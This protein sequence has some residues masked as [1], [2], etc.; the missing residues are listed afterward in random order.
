MKE[1]HLMKRTLCSI[2]ALAVFAF[3]PQA[4]AQESPEPDQ[5]I[6]LDRVVVTVDR[7]E[8]RQF[9]VKRSVDIQD[10]E[11]IARQQPKSIPDLLQ[12][13]PA[14]TVQKTNAGAGAPIIR[15]LIGP[16]NLILFDGIRVSNSTYRTG[17]NQYLALM[18]PW[19]LSSFELLRGPGSVLYGSDAMGG[20]LHGLSKNPRKL[21]DRSWGL[22]GRLSFAS[23]YPGLGGSLQADLRQGDYGGYVGASFDHFGE[24][25]AG[26]G[27]KQPLSDYQRSAIRHKSTVTLAPDLMLTAAL[28]ETSIRGAGRAEKINLGRHRNYDNDDLLSYVRLDRLG[29][30]WLYRMRLNVSY[31][32]THELDSGVR[33]ATSG[34]VVTDRAAC[35]ASS[36]KQVT[37]RYENRDTVHTPGLFATLDSRFWDNRLRTIAGVESYLDVVDSNARDA[38]ATPSQWQN[39]KRGNYSSGSTYASLGAF[40]RGDADLLKWGDSTVTMEAG[41]RLSCFSASAPDVPGLGDVDYADAGFVMSTG[42][43]YRYRDQVHLYTDFSQGFRAPNLQESTVLGDTGAFF[44]VP[45]G[46]LEPVRSDTVEV[47]MKLKT[48][49]FG[50]N[51]AGW[52]SSLS[53][54]F[55]REMLSEAEIANLGIDQ[56]ALG[57]QPVA[58]RVNRDSAWYRGVDLA[59]KTRSWSGLSLFSAVSWVDGEVDLGDGQ[60]VPSRRLPPLSGNAGLRYESPELGIYG[61]FFV[62]YA[63]A[64]HELHPDDVQDYRICE[65]PNRPG[66][67]LADCQGTAGWS[68]LNLRAGLTLTENFT[69]DLR[70]ENLGDTHYRIHGSGLDAPGFNGMLE[71]RGTY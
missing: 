54:L 42:L 48:D 40:V 49:L 29:K 13:Q 1:P 28:F 5:G 33:C 44:E 30:G 50:L 59:L 41:G 47:G 60:W 35:L 61:E 34:G 70:F 21:F 56:A 11:D 68:T 15:G 3:S 71:L 20:V 37:R 32:M 53:N 22:D 39:R 23:A 65:D 38:G 52:Y 55:G 43:G 25:V 10:A 17:P 69:F 12:D 6:E 9:E 46:D 58:R 31:H 36:A 14:V 7:G 64:Q 63:A 8:R 51:M 62:R 16:D 26:G 67:L 24:V 2:W 27:V 57:G 45:N 4:P 19:A 18:D 66:Q